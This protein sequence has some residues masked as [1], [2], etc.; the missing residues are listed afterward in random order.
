VHAPEGLKPLIRVDFPGISGID[1]LKE[2]KVTPLGLDEL[3]WGDF[4]P[5]GVLG[6]AEA[7]D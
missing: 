7:S 4:S 3:A 1:G 6:G 2:P 5:L